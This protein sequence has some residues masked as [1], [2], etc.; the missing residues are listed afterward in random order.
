MS[1]LILAVFG[2]MGLMFVFFG[3]AFLNGRCVFMLAGYNTMSESERK[4]YDVKAWLKS[5]G[6]TAIMFGILFVLFGVLVSLELLSDHRFVMGIIFSAIC[7][8]I[9]ILSIVRTKNGEKFLLK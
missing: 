5:T 2:I 3:I 6:K 8:G 1:I 9:A 4:K 7:V